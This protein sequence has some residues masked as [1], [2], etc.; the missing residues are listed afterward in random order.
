LID[1]PTFDGLAVA[2]RLGLLEEAH[3]NPSAIASMTAWRAT[4]AS[5][6]ART[7]AA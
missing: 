3:G 6:L 5:R 7:L 1:D 4:Q 2:L